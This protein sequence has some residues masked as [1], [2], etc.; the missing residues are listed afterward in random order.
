MELLFFLSRAKK[1]NYNHHHYP[2]SAALCSDDFFS[3]HELDIK[4]KFVVEG[5]EGANGRGSPRTLI[6]H[7]R[8]E[9]VHTTFWLVARKPGLR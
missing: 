8:L 9:D 1:G 4:K 7:E 6:T 2:V 3:C 5:R